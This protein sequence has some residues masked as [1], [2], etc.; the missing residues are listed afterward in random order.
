MKSVNSRFMV[1]KRMSSSSKQ[2]H[3]VREDEVAGNG[4]L[5]ELTNNREYCKTI[6]LY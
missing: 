6:K 4:V 2:L 5:F 1:W 3:S